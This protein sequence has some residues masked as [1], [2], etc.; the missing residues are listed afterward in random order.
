MKFLLNETDVEVTD[1]A[2][3]SIKNNSGTMKAIFESIPEVLEEAESI[4]EIELGGLEGVNEESFTI[5]ANAV[6]HGYDPRKDDDDFSTAKQC[7]WVSK[8]ML[9]ED[10]L[11][12]TIECLQNYIEENYHEETLVD[13]FHKAFFI[14]DDQIAET[15]NRDDLIDACKHLDIKAEENITDEDLRKMVLNT[16]NKKDIGLTDDIIVV[17]K[18]NPTFCPNFKW[19]K[20]PTNR[21]DN[22]WHVENIIR[23]QGKDAVPNPFET[24]RYRFLKRALNFNKE[25]PKLRAILNFLNTNLIETVVD[26]KYT[27]QEV[28]KYDMHMIIEKILHFAHNDFDGGLKAFLEKY[29]PKYRNAFKYFF[30]MDQPYLMVYD[31]TDIDTQY[32]NPGL[33]F[34]FRAYQCGFD[35][36]DDCWMNF[37]NGTNNKTNR[38]IVFDGMI[39]ALKG[40]NFDCKDENGNFEVISIH[41][42]EEHWGMSTINKGEELIC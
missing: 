33:Y 19:T 39:K 18:N 14:V 38:K 12:K 36:P 28:T 5:Y 34:S 15:M 41:E 24:A 29:F 30:N 11:N 40:E 2:Y 8:S 22:A 27:T 7:F 21:F 35:I 6:E 16:A 1:A 37:Y 31:Y 17:L 10:C 23:E 25:G 32:A 13:N 42:M 9:D 20:L 4:G 3:E 26:G